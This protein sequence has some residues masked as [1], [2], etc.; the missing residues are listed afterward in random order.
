MLFDTNYVLQ[1]ILVQDPTDDLYHHLKSIGAWVSSRAF[2]RSHTLSR[3]TRGVR[4]GAIPQG[5]H[6][7]P[8]HQPN[9]QIQ[10]KGQ[11]IREA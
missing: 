11:R 6:H 7:S 9:L 3:H 10:H 1:P 8:P 4:G 2:S 5:Q